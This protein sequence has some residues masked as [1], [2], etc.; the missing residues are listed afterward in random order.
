MKSKRH[1]SMR[2]LTLF[3]L[4]TC[5]IPRIAAV[6][7]RLRD[8]SAQYQQGRV[9]QRIIGGS[10]P[11][12]F[13]TYNF[14]VAIFVVSGAGHEYFRCG[15]SLITS[16]HVL[17]ASH[18]FFSDLGVSAI[19]GYAAV[20]VRLGAQENVFSGKQINVVQITGHPEFDGNTFEFDVAILELSEIIDVSIYEPVQLAWEPMGTGMAKV[21]GWGTVDDGTLSTQLL[22]G[23]VPIVSHE[24]CAQ[25]YPNSLHL[26]SMLC[27]GYAEGGVDACQGDSGGALLD[28]NLS[29]I[30]IVSWGEG[31]A[32]PSKYGVYS[33]VDAARAFIANVAPEVYQYSPYTTLE[34]PP[35]QPPQPPSGVVDFFN[36]FQLFSWLS[37]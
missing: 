23:S 1:C 6:D 7:V 8:E 18:C 30:G 32:L 19:D 27:A 20:K 10:V 15:G 14:A 24:N 2:A 17:S 36:L 4:S 12:D 28:S 11:G 5:L 26:G 13:G 29:Q 33:R 21:I 3:L 35:P 25:S 22:E 37:A 16:T 9:D 34:P 31:C